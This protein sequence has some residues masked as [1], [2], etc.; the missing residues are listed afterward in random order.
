[1]GA[2]HLGRLRLLELDATADPQ[3]VCR[4]LALL[5]R[6]RDYHHHKLPAHDPALRATSRLWKPA[7]AYASSRGTDF[8][9]RPLAHRHNLLARTDDPGRAA[10]ICQH[11][12]MP[13]AESLSPD[14]GVLQTLALVF[15][16]LAPAHGQYGSRLG[17]AARRRVRPVHDGAAL[18]LP[19][20]CLSQP[21]AAILELL[22]SGRAVVPRLDVLEAHLHGIPA[23]SH[24]QGSPEA[25]AQVSAAHLPDQG[26]FGDVSGRPFHSYCPRSVRGFSFDGELVEIALRNAG[27]A[28][29]HLR[30]PGGLRFSDFYLYV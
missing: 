23:T 28:A 6:R 3:P 15:D 11:L 8:H 17:P 22:R 9:H 5:V 1:M 16:A 2:S 25:R 7:G 30:R 20:H 27:L 13:G 26:S 24:L 14:R 4:E 12:R 21:R 18:A 19:D 29:A 10:Y